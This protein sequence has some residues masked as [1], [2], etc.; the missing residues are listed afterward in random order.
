MARKTSTQEQDH[1]IDHVGAE[2]WQ[3]VTREFRGQSESAV[4]KTLNGMFPT[5]N[6]ADLAR[7]IRE[8]VNKR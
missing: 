2:N 5:E 8:Q 6:N 1:I 4:L 7:R 3:Q